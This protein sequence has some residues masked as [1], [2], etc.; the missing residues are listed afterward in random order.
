MSFPSSVGGGG[1]IFWYAGWI[2]IHPALGI[3]GLKLRISDE[4]NL[5]FKGRK[6]SRE[7]RNFTYGP[8]V[9]YILYKIQLYLSPVQHSYT[10]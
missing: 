3:T 5:N 10:Q 8:F 1:I 2:A 9:I 6:I 4:F 7:I